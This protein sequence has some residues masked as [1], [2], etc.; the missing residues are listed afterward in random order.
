M[1]FRWTFDRTAEHACS[2]RNANRELSLRKISGGP[3]RTVTR[4]FCDNAYQSLALRFWHNAILFN[5]PSLC[6]S[7][8]SKSGVTKKRKRDLGTSVEVIAPKLRIGRVNPRW[9]QGWQERE[10]AYSFLKFFKSFRNW[11][12]FVMRATVQKEFQICVNMT[13]ERILD[14]NDIFVNLL[15]SIWSILS[16]ICFTQNN[17]SGFLLLVLFCRDRCESE[18]W[19]HSEWQTKKS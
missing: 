4:E 13:K 15:K 10:E 17:S 3:N 8:L 11:R 1:N 5:A 7:T 14:S 6:W 18:F 9:R 2:N 19:M 12:E 16:I